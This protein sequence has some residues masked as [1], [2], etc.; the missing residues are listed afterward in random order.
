MFSTEIRDQLLSNLK[1]LYGD[2]VE[3]LTI[4]VQTE[5]VS[6]HQAIAATSHSP[7]ATWTKFLHGPLN[8]QTEYALRGLLLESEKELAKLLATNGNRVPFDGEMTQTLTC[9]R[10]QPEVPDCPASQ[11]SEFVFIAA[12]GSS[13][14]DLHTD[15]EA[16]AA[17]NSP[18]DEVHPRDPICEEPIYEE[19]ACD[20]P[21]CG[22][23]VYDETVCQAIVIEEPQPIPDE[24]DGWG[25][26]VGRKGKK[27]GRKVV[28][29]IKVIKESIP[30]PEPEPVPDEDYGWGFGIGRKGK[31][32]KKKGRKA[33]EEVEVIEESI[34]EPEPVPSPACDPEPEES[35]PEPESVPSPACDP[36]PEESIPEPESVPSPACD[37]EPEESIPEPESVPS[38]A[39]D[40]E[41]EESTPEPEPVPSLACDPEPEAVVEQDSWLTWGTTWGTSPKK[42]KEKMR[43]TV[44]S[45]GAGAQNVQE[46]S[47]IGLGV[48]QLAPPLAASIPTPTAPRNGQTVVF[49][50][51]HPNH[52]NKTRTLEVML[53]LTDTTYAAICEAVFAYLDSQ[54]GI[55]PSKR[56]MQIRSG[57]GRNGEVDLSAVEESMWSV[58]MEY[59]CQYTK[60]PEL[61]VDVLDS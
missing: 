21:V 57:I 32:E 25:F 43:S 19:P 16:P 20:E 52:N 27:K 6:G 39:Y 54:E 8:S 41:P 1:V 13:L 35:I 15:E 24:D 18:V 50:I 17:L 12:P 31:K 14:S 22:E 7:E 2:K 53:F 34:P 38:P 5:T 49:T 47:E 37:P 61:T 55:V 56:T 9:G 44:P 45:D 36:E 60:L 26:G 11:Q 28:E 4:Y 10:G 23:P 29:E 3:I 42:N 30:E 59:F 40:P 58:Y 51:R 48:T 33:V 46:E